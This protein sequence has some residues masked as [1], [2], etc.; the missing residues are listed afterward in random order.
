MHEIEDI[1]SYDAIVIGSGISGLGLSAL[2]SKAGKR[3][4]TLEWAK[5]IGGRAH[6][7]EMKGHIVNVGGPRAGLENGRVDA[8]FAELGLEPGWEIC[9]FCADPGNGLYK[10]S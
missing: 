4:L 5:H 10:E 6:S 8:L 7:F 1:G 2:L 3:V 9:A